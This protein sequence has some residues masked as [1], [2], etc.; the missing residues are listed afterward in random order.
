MWKSGDLGG[1]KFGLAH[2]LPEKPLADYI[3]SNDIW[4]RRRSSLMMEFKL[5]RT[6]GKRSS[7]ESEDKIFLQSFPQQKSK[8]AL[9]FY[10]AF[11]QCSTLMYTNFATSYL[12]SVFALIIHNSYMLRPYILIIFREL[13]VWW[14]CTAHM[15]TCQKLPADYINNFTL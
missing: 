9:N 2:L 6:A 11:R 3:M 1:Q 10:V 4:M 7:P 8:P 14:A 12:H 15:A 5:L 13:L